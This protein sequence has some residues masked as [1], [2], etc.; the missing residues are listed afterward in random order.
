MHTD[1]SEI[2]DLADLILTIARKIT[3]HEIDDESFVPLS[4]LE[5]VVMRCIDR[6]PGIGPSEIASELG[7]RSGNMSAALRALDAKGLILRSP[8]PDDRR[9]V[10]VFPTPKA[11]VNI[12]MLRAGWIRTLAPVIPPDADLTS[13]V[14]VLEQIDA[15][16][17]A[18]GKQPS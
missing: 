13:V 7:L 5:A 17:H 14:A 16:F 3:A 18:G 4:N 6:H 8:D 2:S 11:A 12:E 1:D 9:A 10:R 15:R